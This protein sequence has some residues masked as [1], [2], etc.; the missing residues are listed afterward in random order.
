MY[1]V[2][3]YIHY[4]IHEEKKTRQMA[5]RLSVSDFRTCSFFNSE[6]HGEPKRRSRKAKA[7]YGVCICNLASFQKVPSI[8][9]M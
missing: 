3:T 8:K 7:G 2:I 5:M 9:A 1:Y 4:R 6:K